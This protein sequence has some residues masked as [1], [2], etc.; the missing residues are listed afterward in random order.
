MVGLHCLGVV[1]D[2]SAQIPPCPASTGRH[3]DGTGASIQSCRQERVLPCP[4]TCY[5]LVPWAK[6]IVGVACA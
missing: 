1:G 6:Q 5:I 2:V 4:T 3:L